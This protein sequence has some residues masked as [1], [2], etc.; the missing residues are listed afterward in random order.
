MTFNRSLE[1]SIG[2]DINFLNRLIAEG[3]FNN[4]R[5]LAVSHCHS[6]SYLTYKLIRSMKN[7]ETFHSSY[8][9]YVTLEDLACL[10]RSCPKLT[11]LHFR[12][13][14]RQE[15]GE[16]LKNELRSGFQRLEHLSI[17]CH[18]D[19]DSFLVIREMLQ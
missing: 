11:Q 10:F 7:L 19:N 4:N 15:L 2:S 13:P 3:F 12:L 16:D 9:S 6:F 18:M 5:Q 14:E 1:V 8:L 17:D